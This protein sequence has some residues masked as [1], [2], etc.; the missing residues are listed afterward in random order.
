[1]DDFSAKNLHI[2]ILAA[3][4][5]TRMRSSKPKVLHTLGA[6]SL[7][8]HVLAVSN[9]LEP[10]QIHVVYGHG[11]DQLKAQLVD[12]NIS[13]V[14]QQEQ[15]GTGHAVLQVLPELPQS[16]RVLILYGDVPLIQADTLKRLLES[17]GKE[18]L[19]A[20]SLLTMHCEDPF[21]YGRILREKGQ[22][23]GIR[24]QKDASDAEKEIREVNTG[25][26]LAWAA[27]LKDWL[28]KLSNENKQSEY[29]LTD[30]VS[31]AAHD[32]IPVLTGRPTHNWEVE[33][34]NDRLQLAN[35]ERVFQRNQAER[36]MR[37]GLALRDPN[38]FDLRGSLKHGDDCEIDIN[39]VFEGNNRLGERV[40]IG[41]NCV[42]KNASLGD[43]TVVEA[44]S[45][46]EN[47]E[48]EQGVTIGPFGRI[49]PGTR[50]Q[51][52]A[53]VG[54]FVELKN[55]DLGAGSKVNHL[56]YVGDSQVGESVNIGAGTITC[57]YDGVNKHKTHIGNGVFVGSNSALVAPVTIQEGATIGAGSVITKP[58]DKGDL[59]I[60]RARQKNLSGWA[61]PV[62]ES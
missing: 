57:N 1:M 46:V 25:I 45:I 43:D 32:R 4:K 12:K 42:L 19:P 60:G 58:V 36:L 37:S 62:K 17:H 40:R 10:A 39:C 7:L 27:H 53:R 50:L 59:A 23:I 18:S 35:L 9:V 22:V 51:K 52:G 6:N 8:E 15:L 61:R 21:G 54:N 2:V 47:S 44:N 34:V 20:F 48:A 33:G 30:V 38:R 14:E 26:M 49:R 5:G 31:M 56:S 55:T 13:W 41:P 28:P 24:E 11:G 29:Y 16:A 3:G